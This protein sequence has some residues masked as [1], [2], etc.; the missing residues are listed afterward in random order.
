MSQER[1]SGLS[2]ISINYAIAGQ[3]SYDD[4]IDEGK[5]V[6]GLRVDGSCAI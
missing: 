2:V 1:L 3:M 5:K 4:V 6:Q